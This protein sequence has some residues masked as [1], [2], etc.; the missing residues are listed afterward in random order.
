MDERNPY[1]PPDAPVA[2]GG[3]SVRIPFARIAAVLA[4]AFV[5]VTWGSVM[6]PRLLPDAAAGTGHS[7]GFTGTLFI[8]AIGL[9]VAVGLWVRSAW[10]WWVGL[11]AGAYQL[12]S[13]AL[14]FVVVMATGDPIGLLTSLSMLV[15]LAFMV[16][17]L[18][19]PT[20]R[21]CMRA[22][23]GGAGPVSPHS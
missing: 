18:L 6:L 19:P 2:A 23:R 21:S 17:L 3:A 4:L 13:F 22:T 11:I 5:A 1:S 15:L 16:V 10:G 9:A 8:T 12:L 7:M 14:F 20:M